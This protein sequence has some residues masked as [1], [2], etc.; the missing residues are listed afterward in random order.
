MQT[1]KLYYQD[2]YLREFSANVLKATLR[3]DQSC[4]V[5][6][7]RTAF[8]PEGGGQ[9]CD[10]GSLSGLPIL[11]VQT[12]D[13]DIVHTVAGHPGDGVVCGRIDW[14]RRFDFMQQ[15]TGEHL[16]SGI[17]LAT[18]QAENIGFHLS[19]STCQI[20]TTLPALTTELAAELEAAVNA[21]IF[22]NLPVAADF[23][24]AAE[25]AR[26]R[27][28]KQPGKEFAQIRLVSIEGRDCCPCGGTHVAA[29]GEVGLFKIRGWEKRKQNIRI[30]FV[31][32]YRALAD[33][34]L[35]HDAAKTVATALSAPVDGL[36]A[37][38]E[39]N[40]EKLEALQKELS[41]TRKTYHAE[42]AARLLS[43]AAGQSSLPV[44]TQTFSGYATADLQDFAGQITGAGGVCLLAAASPGSA[45]LAF[46]FATAT[47]LPIPL[48]ELLRDCLAPVGGKGG[49]TALQAQGGST[50]GDPAAL[51]AA[52][53]GRLR[54]HLPP[55]G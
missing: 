16:L 39:K 11:S 45:K 49:G 18:R 5:I 20:D 40:Q 51:L 33:Y 43:E 34:Q 53:A 35:K 50:A 47:A 10:L 6:L 23:V 8:Y 24:D 32:G 19:Q 37:A 9:P 38:F 7:D 2:P 42:L 1:E 27:L 17:L 3:P 14:Q 55:P 54:E 36:L 46:Y 12:V 52:A 21:A 26:R 30:D 31:C 25:L 48:N 28:R 13:G 4:D 29:T 22:A 15:H 41:L 44:V